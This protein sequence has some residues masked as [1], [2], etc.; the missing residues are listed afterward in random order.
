MSR[1]IKIKA[2]TCLALSLLLLGLGWEQL[3]WAREMPV[4]D[5]Q[6]ATELPQ[7]ED[8]EV[9]VGDVPIV[10]LL[11]CGPTDD[12]VFYLYGHTALRVQVG[13]EDLVYNYGYFSP[14]QEHFI[15][16]FIVGKPMYSVGVISF[17]DFLEEYALQGRSVSEQVLDLTPQE[18]E[19][20]YSYLEWNAL[21]ENRDYQYNFYFDNCATKPRDLIERYTGGLEYQIDPSQM[22]SF[23]EA[24]RSLSHTSSWYTMGADCC[25]G[26]KSDEPMTLQDAAFLPTL[27]EQEMDAAVRKTDGKPIVKEKRE[28]IP[29]TKEIGAGAYGD[30]HWPTWT[31]LG[32]ALLYGILRYLGY[33]QQEGGETR[34]GS[35]RKW[36]SIL[37]SLLQK[38]LYLSA[39][40]AGVI[41]WFLAFGSEHPHTFPNAQL[42]L[43]HPLYLIL[44]V[45][46]HC[47]RYQR[48][49][50]WL[51]FGNF[52]AIVLYLL[53]GYKQ[54]LPIGLPI[55]A[56]LL[57]VDQMLEW[58]RLRKSKK[59]ESVKA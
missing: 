21:P 54:A 3:A 57:G 5:D 26:W 46:S 27:L 36:H 1:P 34:R 56:L 45:T 53:M 6:E 30:V 43:L 51:Y 15:L 8:K 50:Y 23:R 39:G 44:L 11:T 33:I 48:T 55:I 13:G 29:Q 17:E 4:G 24:I 2:L 18:A 35:R 42:L 37:L 52:V 16:N 28:W 20:M 14:S 12:Y 9:G 22:P 38:V 47:T 58:R 25:L 10:S 31:F 40:V 7:A 32:L 59:S 41:V 19:A 49:N